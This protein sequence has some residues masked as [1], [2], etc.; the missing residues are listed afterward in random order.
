M[1]PGHSRRQQQ[2]QHSQ[3]QLLLLLLYCC[4]A[5]L[6]ASCCRTPHKW[7]LGLRTMDCECDSECNRF[8]AGRASLLTYIGRI[9]HRLPPLPA[10]FLSPFLCCLCSNLTNLHAPEN[11]IQVGEWKVARAAL[12]RLLDMEKLQPGQRGRQVKQGDGERGE[13][14]RGSELAGGEMTACDWRVNNAD[15]WEHFNWTEL[16]CSEIECRQLNEQRR[17]Q[18]IRSKKSNRSQ[19][20]SLNTREANKSGQIKPIQYR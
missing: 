14:R 12:N 16:S 4:V 13:G 17:C 8:W 19:K 5:V 15:W 18:E 20:G 6:V 10:P 11:S 1:R 7:L 9:A 3:Q 2:Q